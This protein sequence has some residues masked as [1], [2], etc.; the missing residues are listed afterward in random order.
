MTWVSDRTGM[1]LY[2]MLGMLVVLSSIYVP[3]LGAA[4]NPLLHRTDLSAASVCI[5]AAYSR[6]CIWVDGHDEH[7]AGRFHRRNTDH[8][9][10]SA[11]RASASDSSQKKRKRSHA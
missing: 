10:A 7:R 1:L 4:A 9:A 6:R 5:C 2:T 3:A 11:A 8:R